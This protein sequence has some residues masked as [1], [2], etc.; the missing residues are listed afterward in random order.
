[1]SVAC[2]VRLNNRLYDRQDRPK[3]SQFWVHVDGA[4]ENI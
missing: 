1:M 3:I 2:L 4:Q